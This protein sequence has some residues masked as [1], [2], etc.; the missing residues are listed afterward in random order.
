MTPPCYT[1]LDFLFVYSLLKICLLHL[2]ITPWQVIQSCYQSPTI[3]ERRPAKRDSKGKWKGKDELKADYM[4]L[5]FIVYLRILRRFNLRWIVIPTQLS[6]D[7][8][9]IEAKILMATDFHSKTIFSYKVLSYRYYIKDSYYHVKG[10]TVK[11]APCMNR[12][13]QHVN[14]FYQQED[15]TWWSGGRALGWCVGGHGFNSWQDHT[16]DFKYG[17]LCFL[18]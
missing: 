9:R 3:I 5:Y 8:L 7:L 10:M 2:I 4:T 11:Q 17:N 18:A 13:L 6:P 1:T 15:S 14:V 16:K 12:I